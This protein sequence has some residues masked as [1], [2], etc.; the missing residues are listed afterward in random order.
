MVFGVSEESH[1]ERLA[2]KWPAAQ[3]LGLMHLAK[4]Q[5]QGKTRTPPDREQELGLDMP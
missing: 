5:S 2:P 1:S 4:Q 3:C